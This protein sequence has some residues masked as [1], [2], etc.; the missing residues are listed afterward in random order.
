L[1]E[2]AINTHPLLF[3][4]PVGS[5]AQVSETLSNLA[6]RKMENIRVSGYIVDQGQQA[7]NMCLGGAVDTIPKEHVCWR[8]TKSMSPGQSRKP[9]FAQI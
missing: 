6:T 4:V 8:Y 7:L 9:S 5:A 3:T 2:E 1:I